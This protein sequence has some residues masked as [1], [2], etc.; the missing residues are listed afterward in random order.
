MKRYLICLLSLLLLSGA[1]TA[2][3]A[4]GRKSKKKAQT[5]TAAPVKKQSEY[6]KLFKDKKV[7]TSK[8][9]IMTH[10]WSNCP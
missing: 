4:K 5:T 3:F 10:C 1:S 8:G 6:D 9:G 2:T 7:K